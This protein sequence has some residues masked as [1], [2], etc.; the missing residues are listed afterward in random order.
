[1]N[2]EKP[3]SPEE[4]GPPGVCCNFAERQV[5][6]RLA[7]FRDTHCVCA[8]TWPTNVSCRWNSPACLCLRPLSLRDGA[9]D[10]QRQRE[11]AARAVS[12]FLPSASK[13]Q[14]HGTTTQNQTSVCGLT[15]Q[16]EPLPLQTRIT[17]NTLQTA[18][19]NQCSAAECSEATSN[20]MWSSVTQHKELF[21][22]AFRVSGCHRHD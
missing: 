7:P 18:E 4:T 16:P 17:H 20:R 11:R 15:I 3:P 8:W 9:R 2:L 13:L 1:M 10:T 22:R 12:H 5:S 14:A 6:L 21:E 19:A